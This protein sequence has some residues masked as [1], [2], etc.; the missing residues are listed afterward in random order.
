MLTRCKNK[1]GDL[2]DLNNYRAIA[3]S[4][5]FSKLFESVIAETLYTESAVDKFQFGF[6]SG[7]S[8]SL[9]TSVFKQ[10][11][12][13]FTARGSHVFSC[14]SDYRKAFDKVNYWKLFLKLMDD[15]V[16]YRVIKL[17]AF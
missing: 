6:K 11:V 1:S 14:F 13:Y 17:L 3:I 15:C 10:T 2:S 4:T 8:T 7:H 9:C 16:D 12:E 5:A